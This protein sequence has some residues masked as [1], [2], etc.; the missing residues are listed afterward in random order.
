MACTCAY[1]SHKMEGAQR[2]RAEKDINMGQVFVWCLFGWV[3]GR[4]VAFH[5]ASFLF[6]ATHGYAQ[7]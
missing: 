1:D 5:F 3:C 7:D 4:L 2:S 6:Q